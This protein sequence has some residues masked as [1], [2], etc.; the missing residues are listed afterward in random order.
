M[1]VFNIIAIPL[2]WVLKV[3]YDIVRNYGMALLLFTFV[4]KLILLPLSW[5]QK[6]SSIRMAAIQPLI[7]DINK[8]Y[9]NNMEKR[10]Q[11][12]ARVQ[13]ENGISA[14]AGCLPMLIQLPILFGLVNVIYQPL[15]HLAKLSAETITAA[16]TVA[17]TLGVAF[18]RYSPE[19]T[20]LTAVRS[21]PDAFSSVL[22]AEQISYI[23]DI[24]MTFFGL[25][26]TQ[27]PKI[28]EPS[29]LWIIPILSVASMLAS[30]IIMM[31]LNGQK[32]EG[33]MK[34]MPIYTTVMFGY[35][36]FAMP[37]GV[38][39]YWIFSSLFA[40]LQ[41][42]FLRIFFDPEK[43]KAKIEQQMKESRKQAKRNES[44]KAAPGADGKMTASQAEL[45]KKRLEKA[46]ASEAKDD[47]ELTE[48]QR[49]RLEKARELEKKTY[50]AK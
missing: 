1:G 40:I 19:S 9:A 38:T 10:Q 15:T 48:Q 24:N 4:T 43:E 3:I 20:I 46:R 31:K 14:T 49:A 34:W 33:A 45:G 13:Q 42:F 35:F 30:Q 29:I 37:A 21:N 27:I 7:N 50:G 41:D 16:K 18:S 2:G 23:Q 6:Q 11:E 5:K 32:M 22:S 17:E 25:D 47:D 36:A 12:M 28:S 26:L 39:V 44:K 8:K